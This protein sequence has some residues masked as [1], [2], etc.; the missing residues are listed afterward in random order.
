MAKKKQDPK[1][2]PSG[3]GE[4]SENLAGHIGKN[5]KDD[6]SGKLPPID[7]VAE[8]K[9]AAAKPE[10]GGK[11]DKS[12][13]AGKKKPEAD[14]GAKSD[15][16]PE[17]DKPKEGGDLKL[18]GITI[19]KKADGVEKTDGNKTEKPPKA[20]NADPQAAHDKKELEVFQADAKKAEAAKA[21]KKQREARPPDG[22]KVVDSTPQERT[23]A[24]AKAAIEKA[25][26]PQPPP[27]PRDAARS[28][29]TET[30]VYID[31]SELHPFK[32][33]PFDVR[34][35][36][37]MTKL[38]E[39]VKE[40]GVDQ[41]ALVR[42][43]E[44][45]GY[46]MV[47]GHRRQTASEQAGIKNLP[48]IVRNMSDEEAVL[49]MAETNFTTR[50][51]ILPSERA[52]ALK[53]QLDAIKKQGARFEGVAKGDVG[54]RSVEIIADRN[55]MNY[56]TVQ[57]YVAL[58]NLAPELMKFVD[59]GKVKFIP[60]VEMS[61]IKKKNQQYIA[62]TIESD[63][64]APSQKQAQRMRELD[65]EG[66]LTGDVIDGIL[67][68]DSKKEERKVI[69]TEKELGKYFGREKTPAEMKATILKAMDDFKAK[70][71]LEFGKTEKSKELEK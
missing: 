69:L 25:N 53:M 5:I 44:G 9:D 2:P 57:R 15:K 65:K 62:M 58:N 23:A 10:A 1:T 4:K 21:P 67:L 12:A 29:E 14:K 26:E 36:A 8:M 22:S 63:G 3:A 52:A 33:H 31:L 24:M 51:K 71:P 6:L 16:P 64:K 27:P 34:M 42:P 28:G 68:E 39:S 38:V 61:Y 66:K 45:G 46:E 47:A 32:D 19:H 60:A 56:K 55:E 49:A 37:D 50:E 17:T 18:T 41:P 70:N 13:A 48:C 11:A 43:R 30:I 40:R 59:E 20:E 35:D 54:K 7:S